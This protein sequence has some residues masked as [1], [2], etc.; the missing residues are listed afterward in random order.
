LLKPYEVVSLGPNFGL[1][2]MVNDA[3]TLDGLFKKLSLRKMTLK[4]FFDKNYKKNKA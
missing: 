2:E 4:D 3:T 1:V